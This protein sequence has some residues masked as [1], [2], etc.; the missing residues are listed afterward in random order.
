M[1]NVGTNVVE[2]AIAA[3]AAGGPF[4]SID[5][6]V[7]RVQS[8]DLNK[9]SLESLI[10][11]GALDELGERGSLLLNLDRILDYARDAQRTRAAGQTSLF[12]PADGAARSHLRLEP[13]AAAEKRARLTWE[14]ELLGLYVSEHPLEEYRELLEKKRTTA[15]SRLTEQPRDA[16]VT[17]GG[18][19]AGAKRIVTKAGSPMLFVTLEDLTGRTEVLVFPRVLEQTAALWQPDKVILVKGRLS[20]DRDEPKVLADEVIEVA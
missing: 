7:E 8:K 11:C 2:A 10:K 9:K 17:V 13:A 4:T 19:V 16:T 20:R 3:R 5:D 18:L 1:K 12:G 6:F 15:V 14:K